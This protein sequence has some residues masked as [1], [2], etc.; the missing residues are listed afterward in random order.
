MANA[1]GYI[2]IGR[3]EGARIGACLASLTALSDRVVYVDSASS[4]DSVSIAESLAAHVERLTQGPFSAARARN[5]GF[6]ALM[7]RWPD[8]ELVMLIDGDCVLID[9]FAEAAATTLAADQ[10]IGIVT[11]RCRERRPGASVYNLLCDLEWDGPIGDIEACGGIFMA[12][13]SAFR[14]VSGFNPE[15]IAAEDDDFCIRVRATGRRVVRID[16]DMCWHDADMTRFG[17]WWARAA[18]AGHAYA[19]VGD[20]HEGYFAAPRRRAWIWGLWIPLIAIGGAPI[21]GG[22]SLALLS[23]YGVSF[24]RTALRFTKET[25]NPKAAAI[26]A[27][28]LILAKFANLYGILAYRWKKRFGEVRIVEYKTAVDGRNESAS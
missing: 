11:G 9:G 13:A 5:H 28:F 17:Q 7:A 19:Q 4:D 26:H 10:D 21:T 1:I 23:L 16:H 2:A 18:R 12:R 22:W 20:L 3:N 8:T 27:G 14:D 25:G 24:A 6:D 15:V